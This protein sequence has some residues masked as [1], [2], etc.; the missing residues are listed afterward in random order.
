VS[1]TQYRKRRHRTAHVFDSIVNLRSIFNNR[2]DAA[3]FLVYLLNKLK[4]ALTTNI[5]HELAIGFG[6]KTLFR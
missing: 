5:A 2:E 4:V 6:T 3:L 1:I